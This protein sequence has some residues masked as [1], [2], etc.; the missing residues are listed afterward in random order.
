MT[1]TDESEDTRARRA[2]MDAAYEVN[3]A[4]YLRL[5]AEIDATYPPGR[6]VAIDGGRI[7]ADAET[8]PALNARL[9]EIGRTDRHPLVVTAG[10][11]DPEPIETIGSTFQF[12]DEP[13]GW[14]V[15]D[16]QLQ[17]IEGHLH[18]LI[19]LRTQRLA[20]RFRPTP[21][22]SLAAMLAGEATDDFKPTGGVPEVW[23]FR[24]PGMYGGFRLRWV[25][26][27][28]EAELESVSFSRIGG[29][30]GQ[31]HRITAAGSEL[32]ESGMF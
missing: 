9:N 1:E 16:R 19:R 22:P 7:V 6:Q 3:F 26:D 12:D 20:D 32:V 24:V 27:G 21:L 28:P 30:S 10:E 31:R 4:A 29:G 2:A 14:A 8:Y 18:A 11:G 25:A 15:P 13:D 23:F 17:A 5:R